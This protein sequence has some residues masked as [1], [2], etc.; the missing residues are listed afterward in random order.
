MDTVNAPTI[1]I[2][3]QEVVRH[4]LTTNPDYIVCMGDM[5]HYHNT[6]YTPTLNKSYEFIDRISS[7]KP[8][9]I[10]VGNHDMR[11]QVG[12]S[13][14]VRQRRQG[15]NQKHQPHENIQN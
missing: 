5:L 3:I 4:I 2:F 13:E 9:Y 11:G 8:T 1:D 6:V 12:I 14:F 10:I 7:L 15:H